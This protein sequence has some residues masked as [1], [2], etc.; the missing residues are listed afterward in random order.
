MPIVSTQVLNGW[1]YISLFLMNQ[2]GLVKT[3]ESASES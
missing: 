3:L 1:E 2:W